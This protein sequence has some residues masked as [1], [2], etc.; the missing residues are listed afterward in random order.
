M[1]ETGFRRREWSGLALYLLG[2]ALSFGVWVVLQRT[3]SVALVTDTPVCLSVQQRAPA[4]IGAAPRTGPSVPKPSSMTADELN[5]F[6]AEAT[7]LGTYLLMI[8]AAAIGVAAAAHAV[9]SVARDGNDS[10]GTTSRKKGIWT[11]VS[12]GLAA[13]IADVWL[14]RRHGAGFLYQLLFT[15][16]GACPRLKDDVL[17]ARYVGE[18]PGFL[19]AAAMAVA[20]IVITPTGERIAARVQLMQRLLYVASVIFVAGILMCHANFSL[21]LANWAGQASDDKLAKALQGVVASGGIQAGVGYSALIAIFYLPARFYLAALTDRLVSSSAPPGPE[22]TRK[23]ARAQLLKDNG[24]SVSWLDDAKQILA[25]LA[26][27]LASPLFD[28]IAKLK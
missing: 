28:A 11:V 18:C 3:P 9:W 6:S 8:L 19:I 17:L 14:A 26:P 21:V 2:L 12:I 27:V 24:V 10:G 13:A 5:L 23:A 1:R 20:S 25:L 4:T 7:Q 22:I 16:H 15:L